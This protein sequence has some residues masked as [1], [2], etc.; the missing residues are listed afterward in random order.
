MIE[1]GGSAGRKTGGVAE[2]AG[3]AGLGLGSG[4]A[5]RVVGGAV[6]VGGAV[7]VAFGPQPLS[8]SVVKTTSI[9]T[10]FHGSFFMI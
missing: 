1:P 5:S 10:S 6:S 4:L 9:A 8:T 7:G 3:S 2:A